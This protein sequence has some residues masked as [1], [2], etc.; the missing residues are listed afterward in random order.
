MQQL[1]QDSIAIVRHFERPTLFIIFTA[2]PKWKKIVDALL[3]GQ[4]AVDRPDLVAQVFD[5]K[6]RQFLNK[7]RHENIFGRVLGSVWTIEY[8]KR[9]LLLIH[10]LFFCIQMIGSLL[11]RRLMR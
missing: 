4:S 7:L 8:Q 1:Y 3:P 2:N 10:L 11:Q 6:Q 9:G 5:L